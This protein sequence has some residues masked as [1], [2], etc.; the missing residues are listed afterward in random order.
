MNQTFYTRQYIFYMK[1]DSYIQQFGVKA[2]NTYT[3]QIKTTHS[4][5]HALPEVQ[6]KH[7]TVVPSF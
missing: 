5:L 2:L 1:A 7:P 3:E 4:V 6:E